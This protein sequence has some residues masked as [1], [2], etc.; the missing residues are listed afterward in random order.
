MQNIAEGL[1]HTIEAGL[2]LDALGNFHEEVENPPKLEPLDKPLQVCCH[3]VCIC[4]HGIMPLP[5]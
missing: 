3:W 5:S 4:R 2:K 1:S